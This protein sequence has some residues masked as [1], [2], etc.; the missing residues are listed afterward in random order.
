MSLN[1]LQRRTVNQRISPPLI[2]TYKQPQQR[3]AALWNGT[4]E[5]FESCSFSNMAER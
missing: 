3:Y 2:H 1:V 4:N 5:R